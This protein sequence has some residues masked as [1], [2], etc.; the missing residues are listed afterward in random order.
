MAWK[1]D[2]KLKWTLNTTNFGVFS[3]LYSLIVKIYVTFKY[4][5]FFY[6]AAFLNFINFNLLLIHLDRMAE[7]KEKRYFSHL[8]K[9]MSTGMEFYS[10]RDNGSEHNIEFYIC[11][12]LNN[13]NIFLKQLSF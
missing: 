2:E 6:C 11:K 8:S 1:L 7:K 13:T 4:E 3:F 12:Y 5:Y 10:K 9:F